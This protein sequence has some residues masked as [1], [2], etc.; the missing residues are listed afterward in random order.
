VGRIPAED[1]SF[2]VNGLWPCPGVQ[3]GFEAVFEPWPA[4][5][6]GENQCWWDFKYVSL[7]RAPDFVLGMLIPHVDFRTDNAL[8]QRERERDT[9]REKDRYGRYSDRARWAGV[10]VS[11]ADVAFVLI[12]V[13]SIY[14]QMHD[15]PHWW[16]VCKAWNPLFLPS[17]VI[18]WALSFGPRQSYLGKLLSHGPFVSAGHFAYGV[19]MWSKMYSG[20]AYSL[21]FTSGTTMLQ[22]VIFLMFIYA[23]SWTTF[24]LVEEPCGDVARYMV[25]HVSS[26]TPPRQPAEP[27]MK[28]LCDTDTS[29]DPYSDDGEGSSASSDNT[30]DCTTASQGCCASF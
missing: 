5:V 3:A 26:R 29:L 15:V 21:Y 8:P 13:A 11:C 18:V 1:G 12:V 16:A 17:M 9:E 4:R 23:V 28:Q 20:Y 2:D 30:S 27:Q 6:R 14:H 24:R 25:G 22:L 10:A 19:Y 7:P